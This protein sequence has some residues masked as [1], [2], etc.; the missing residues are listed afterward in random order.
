MVTTETHHWFHVM[1][2]LCH[3]LLLDRCSVLSVCLHECVCVSLSLPVSVC[4]RVW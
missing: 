1:D 2:L 4:L 3:A